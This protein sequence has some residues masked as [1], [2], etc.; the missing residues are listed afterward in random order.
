MISI[1]Y[2][3]VMCVCIVG[4]TISALAGT[5]HKS[6]KTDKNAKRFHLVRFS[7]SKICIDVILKSTCDISF[8]IKIGLSGLLGGPVRVDERYDVKRPGGF[9]QE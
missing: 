6:T 9:R 3:P 5:L 7:Y 8:H 2:L 4:F 1:R